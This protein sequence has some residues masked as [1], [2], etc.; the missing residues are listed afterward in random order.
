MPISHAATNKGWGKPTSH[1][2]RAV[3]F[4]SCAFAGSGAELTCSWFVSWAIRW[5]IKILAMC[6]LKPKSG[7]HPVRLIG[8]ADL[9][10]KA[11]VRTLSILTCLSAEPP[12]PSHRLAVDQPIRPYLEHPLCDS[13]LDLELIPSLPRP[14]SS[15]QHDFVRFGENEGRRSGDLLHGFSTYRESFVWSVVT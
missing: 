7:N 13:H 6:F 14:A 8:G 12:Q 11:I 2:N 1:H 15:S 5:L 10:N 4:C 3:Y 9:A